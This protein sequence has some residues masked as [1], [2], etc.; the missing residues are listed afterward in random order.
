MKMKKYLLLAVAVLLLVGCQKEA[1]ERETVLYDA[2]PVFAE[3][4]DVYDISIFL[5]PDVTAQE[6]SAAE[7]RSVYLHNG[8]AYELYTNVFLADSRDSALRMVSGQDADSLSV[9]ETERF[10]LPEYRFA[11]YSEDAAANC[12]A[13]V[14][15]DG[16]QFYAV[17]FSVDEEAGNAYNELMAEVFSTIGLNASDKNG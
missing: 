10:G 14:V 12:R 17:V 11:W 16:E 13:D 15:Q 5:P 8:G 9:I 4:T 3:E 2:A 1:P 6:K 7:N